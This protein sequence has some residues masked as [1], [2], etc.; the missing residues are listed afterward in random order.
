L[1]PRDLAEY[2]KE[3]KGRKMKTYNVIFSE[4]KAKEIWDEMEVDE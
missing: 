3:L 4:E 1:K 2:Q